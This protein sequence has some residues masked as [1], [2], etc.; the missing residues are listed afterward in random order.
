MGGL[1]QLSNP[2]PTA[3]RHWFDFLRFNPQLVYRSTQM[4]R[5][6]RGWNVSLSLRRISGHIA[7]VSA[8]LD[9]DA[10]TKQQSGYCG[11]QRSGCIVFDSIRRWW[12]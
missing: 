8:A 10:L 2:P 6:R 12:L 9:D 7:E 3:R 11:N 1:A 5:Q 4:P